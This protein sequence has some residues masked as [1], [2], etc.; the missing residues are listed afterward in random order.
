[1]G[2][3]TGEVF[4]FPEGMLYLYAS[5]SGTTSGSGVAFCEE[6]GLKLNYGW[7]EAGAF[8]AQPFRVLTGQRADLTISLLYADRTFYKLADATA[9]LHAKF[10]GLITANGLGKSALWWLYSGVIDSVEVSQA[11][12]QV[13]RGSIA[14]HA[15]QWSA[16]GQ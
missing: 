14:F 3:A 4:S 15:S 2:I 10:E 12:G 9:A 11:Q 13:W 6:A 8:N 7:Y 16:F 5:A 1:M